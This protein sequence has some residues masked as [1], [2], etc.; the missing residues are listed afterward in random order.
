MI[1]K[2]WLFFL[3]YLVGNDDVSLTTNLIIYH[4]HQ[5]KHLFYIKLGMTGL[6]QTDVSLSL[7]L[8][9]WLHFIMVGKRVEPGYITQGTGGCGMIP[10]V[11]IPPLQNVK[12]ILNKAAGSH[13][14]CTP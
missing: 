4:V 12:L 2:K 14:P 6:G 8:Y 13:T 1:P 5:Q 3:D 11:Y 7:P 10:D 9:A